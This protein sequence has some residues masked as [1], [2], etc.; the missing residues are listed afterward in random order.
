MPTAFDDWVRGLIVGPMPLVERTLAERSRRREQEVEAAREATREEGRTTRARENI[1]LQIHEQARAQQAT[2]ERTRA[3]EREERGSLSRLARRLRVEQPYGEPAESPEDLLQYKG[4]ESAYK[5]LFPAPKEAAPSTYQDKQGN[6]RDKATGVI[7]ERAAP[8]P[9]QF[10]P[11]EGYVPTYIE[12]PEG[13]IRIHYSPRV[14]PYGL[15]AIA[16]KYTNPTTKKPYTGYFELPPALKETAWDAAMVAQ[17]GFAFERGGG[18]EEGK[19]SLPILK[20]NEWIQPLHF[21][22]PSTSL[23]PP[24]GMNTTDAL[25]AGYFNV[26]DNRDLDALAALDTIPGV[27]GPLKKQS[28]AVITA[29]T[30]WGLTTQGLRGMG[31]QIAQYIPGVTSYVQAEKLYTETKKSFIATLARALSGEKGVLTNQDRDIVA[32]G[33][34]SFSDTEAL[35]NAK[36]AIIDSVIVNAKQAKLKWMIGLPP[37]TEYQ[38]AQEKLLKKLQTVGGATRSVRDTE[39]RPIPG[40]FR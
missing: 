25:K 3:A 32:D 7:R 1:L 26:T 18:G 13:D 19:R 31:A 8:R 6:I 10:A 9:A 27:I 16:Q 33:L 12:S 29:K 40:G 2:Q 14:A 34:P 5:T 38:E 30:K 4:G 21:L 28:D 39:G 15:D 37:S 20:R 35:K 11:P 22:D 36:W 17:R 23:N 24:L